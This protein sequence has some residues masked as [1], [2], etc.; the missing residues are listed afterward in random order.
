VNT[1]KTMRDLPSEFITADSLDMHHPDMAE[2]LLGGEYKV[3]IKS[4]TQ[5]EKRKRLKEVGERFRCTQ[6]TGTPSIPSVHP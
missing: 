3:D 2:K 4:L 5:K 6:L 1:T